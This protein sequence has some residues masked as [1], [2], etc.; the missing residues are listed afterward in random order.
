MS[1][2][3]EDELLEELAYAV[4]SS[5]IS[6]QAYQEIV[7]LITKFDKECVK[8][9]DAGYKAGVIEQKPKVTEEWVEEKATQLIYKWFHKWREAYTTEELRAT[10]KDFIHSLVEEIPAKKLIV[11]EGFVEKWWIIFKEY[12]AGQHSGQLSNFLEQMI[13]ELGLE[14]EEK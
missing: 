4:G 3:K 7:A 12:Q 2:L 5:A 11:P 10:A 14:T 1:R 6:E 13:N 8:S 9:F